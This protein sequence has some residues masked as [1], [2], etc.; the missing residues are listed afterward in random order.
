MKRFLD[1]LLN[2]RIASGEIGGTLGL[3]FLLVFG[4]WAAY[5]SF[6]VPLWK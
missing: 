1:V 6:I 4:I 3:L 5:H 2:V